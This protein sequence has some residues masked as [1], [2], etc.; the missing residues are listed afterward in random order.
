MTS[1]GTGSQPVVR[2]LFGGWTTLSQRSPKTIGKRRHSTK[3]R[4]SQK[5]FVPLKNTQ[6]FKCSAQILRSDQRFS[7]YCLSSEPLLSPVGTARLLETTRLH[8]F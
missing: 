6:A 5:P 2:D 7:L 1:E 3:S 8:R 4:V